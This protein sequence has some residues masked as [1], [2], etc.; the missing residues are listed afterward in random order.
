[1]IKKTITKKIRD[2]L[3]DFSNEKYIEF[4]N[5]KSKEDLDV[6]KANNLRKLII[7]SYN[8][9]NYYKKI[10]EDINLSDGVKTDLNK[11][12]ELQ[13]LT[14]ELL[15]NENLI[16][17]DI[18][19]RKWFYN[20]SGGSTGEPTKFIQDQNY[21][22]YSHASNDYYYN[23]I[24]NI[25]ERYV[26]KVILW[27][28]QIDISKNTGIKSKISNWLTNTTLL[29]S[30]R[31]SNEDMD[32][33]IKTINSYKPD[34]IRGY[35]GSL[36]ALSKYI[37]NK[38]LS[39]YTPKV[40]VGAAES[41][42]NEMKESIEEALGTKTY[43]FYGSR[44]VSNL[45]GECKEGFMHILPSSIIEILNKNNDPV[46]SGDTGKVIVTNLFN[47]SMPFLR[48]QI[49]D[50]ATLGPK[51]CKCGNPLPTLKKIEGR[52]TDYFT[53][54][55]GTMIAGEFFVHLLGVVLND[56]KIKKFQVVQEDY[57]KIKI[58]VVS[59]QLNQSE[60]NNIN[61]KIRKVMGQ[62]CN[63]SWNFVDEIYTTKS[64]K[65]LYT[66]SLISR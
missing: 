63:I 51:K 26:K 47:Y 65:Y 59:D 57:R 36:Y 9:V 35:S 52:I 16:S 32:K 19:K 24:L 53:L 21:L 64:G 50:M 48:Y 12:S 25:D 56:G 33:Y 8:N 62:K 31:M 39:I 11:F 5:I 29:N 6:F 1:M 44:E 27:G 15:K 23:N 7:H 37:K 28:N 14:K 18:N 38:K 2:T 54:E 60:I 49:G 45:A 10:I 20:H 55:D 41:L 30:F 58:L 42:N 22:T 34:I 46:S 66:Q 43:D 61:H 13:L 4:N 17:K 3:G 40:V